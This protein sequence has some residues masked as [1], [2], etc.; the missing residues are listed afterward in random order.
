M[1][2]TLAGRLFHN[3]N[4]NSKKIN[5]SQLMPEYYLFY[6]RPDVCFD[7]GDHCLTYKF[8]KHGRVLL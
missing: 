1:S 3:A 6:M 2:L 7:D 4:S 5:G 8:S